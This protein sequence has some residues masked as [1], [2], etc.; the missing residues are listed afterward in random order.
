MKG[1]PS[2]SAQ[3]ERGPD[4]NQAGKGVAVGAWWVKARKQIKINLA[5]VALAATAMQPSMPR[6]DAREKDRRDRREA[7]KI[8]SFLKFAF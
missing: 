1:D 3:R 8:F 7:L 2:G 5:M 6:G 4:E